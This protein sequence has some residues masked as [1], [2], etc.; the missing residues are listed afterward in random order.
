MTLAEALQ[1]APLIA[2]LRGVTPG[3]VIAQAEAFYEAGVRVIEVPLN[4]PDALESIRLLARNSA[5]R[6]ISG[7]GT[8]L[9]VAE[10][11]QVLSAGGQII[12]AP[13]TDCDVIGRALDLGAL[14]LPGFATASEA[15]TA[16]RAGARTLK[17]FPA[18]TYGV[19]HLKQ[20]KAVLPADVTVLPV[21]GVTADHLQDW[22][23][24]GARGFG[25]GSEI[26]RPGQTPEQAFRRAQHFMA[27][28]RQLA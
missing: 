5:G 10:V 28:L 7:A 15:F 13:N 14:P 16:Y 3:E 21:G 11:E 17:L 24:A 19:G 25:V 8:V 1:Q 2:I 18:V 4:S 6:M 27:A 26:Y 12:V 23:Q 22:W 9:T 20:L